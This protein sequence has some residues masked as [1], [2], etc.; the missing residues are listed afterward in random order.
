MKE[1]QTA[2]VWSTSSAAEGCRCGPQTAYA[3]NQENTNSTQLAIGTNDD[4]FIYNNND[5]RQSF[6]RFV[7][8]E[9]LP[10]DY[11]DNPRNFG[12]ESKR[13]QSADHICKA[14]RKKK[15]SKRLQSAEIRLLMEKNL[16]EL[17][18]N[19]EIQEKYDEGSDNRSSNNDEVDIILDDENIIDVVK[20]GMKEFFYKI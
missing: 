1:I 17:N 11:F 18:E 10:L 6:F 15:W 2:D 13:L 16:D 3:N 19:V 9:A 8:Q 4:I 20:V 14:L 7:I 12:V 5:I